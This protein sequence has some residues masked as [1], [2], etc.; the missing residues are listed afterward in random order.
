VA[1]AATP[2]A[3]KERGRRAKKRIGQSQTARG[4]NREAQTGDQKG[5]DAVKKPIPVVHRHKAEAGPVGGK[6]ST[7]GP[8]K[9]TKIASTNA[10]VLTAESG[11]SSERECTRKGK[12]RIQGK[13]GKQAHE[14]EGLEVP[15]DFHTRREGSGGTRWSC[16]ED[17]RPTVKAQPILLIGKQRNA[18][19]QDTGGKRQYRGGQGETTAFDGRGRGG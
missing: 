16:R 18:R 2:Q 13:G 10:R 12:K 15:K 6:T 4:R 5:C 3:G 7:A 9:K 11:G 8:G 1:G 14:K 19:G 17:N